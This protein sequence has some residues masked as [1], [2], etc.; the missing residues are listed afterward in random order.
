MYTVANLFTLFIFIRL[1][2]YWK[3]PLA[4]AVTYTAAV[5]AGTW[6]LLE[7]TGPATFRPMEPLWLWHAVRLVA[8]VI[9]F[10]LLVRLKTVLKWVGIVALTPVLCWF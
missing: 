1:S 6:F 3:R 5:I 7:C 9:Y 2:I 10:T 8:A 4:L